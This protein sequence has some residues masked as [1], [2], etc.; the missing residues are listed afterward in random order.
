[1]IFLYEYVLDFYMYN[2]FIRYS[3]F[4]QFITQDWDSKFDNISFL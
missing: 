2:N 4:S 1:M 3:Y